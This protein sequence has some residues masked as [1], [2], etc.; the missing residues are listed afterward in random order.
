MKA[1]ENYLGEQR[2][3]PNSWATPSTLA[4]LRSQIQSVAG[5]RR[6]RAVGSGHSSSDVAR[7]DDV[8]IDISRL[9]RTLPTTSFRPQPPG[10]RS[11]ERLYRVEAGI[12]V[13]DLNLRLYQSGLALHNMGSFDGQTIIGAI[14][15]GTHGTGIDLGALADSVVSI[16]MFVV[17]PRQGKAEVSLL[18]IEPQPFTEALGSDPSEQ[19][20]RLEVDPNLFHSA[21]VSFGCF[22]VVYALTL[23]VREAYWLE[24]E[25]TRIGWSQLRPNLIQRARSNARYDVLINPHRNP[26]FNNDRDCLVKIRREIPKQ[27]GEPVRRDR[28]HQESWLLFIEHVFGTALLGHHLSHH[29]REFINRFEKYCRRNDGKSWRS[30][31]YEILRMGI[32]EKV[33]AWSNEIAVPLDQSIAAIDA[34]L[35]VAEEGERQ[36]TFHTSPLGVRFMAAS[37]HWMAMQY[38]RPTCTIETPL[39]KGTRALGLILQRVEQ[40]LDKLGGRPHWG[41]HNDLTLARIR[42]LYP[43]T[44]RWLEYFRRFNEF[45]TFH[46]AFTQRVGFI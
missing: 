16:E 43:N 5:A 12:T 35:Q 36:R 42:R 30:A 2:V 6:M 8:L 22:G 14:S 15:T 19:D 13:R 18:R 7:P 3:R 44:D 17:E 37:P 32:G 29:P 40:A 4:E 38:A 26:D 34:I 11:D 27:K 20:M 9:N 31:S 45:R 23:R 46:N 1:W 21:V 33:R 24:E 28:T 39:L 10:L 25:T 41:Q